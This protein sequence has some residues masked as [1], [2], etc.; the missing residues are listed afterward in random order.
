MSKVEDHIAIREL[1]ARY[2]R[3][4]DYGNPEAWVECF[5]EDGSFEMGSKTLAAGSTDLLAFAKKMIPTMKVKHCTTDAI[6]EVDGDTGTH[7]AYL[8]LVGCD[9]KVSVINSGRY[10]DAVV[11]VNGQWKFKQ[12]VVDIDDKS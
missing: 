5:T 9:D 11:R 3:A 10:I 2:N 6:V 4:F 1:A 7:D 12:R 8:I